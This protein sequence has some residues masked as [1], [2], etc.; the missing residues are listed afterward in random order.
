MLRCSDSSL[1]TGWTNDL[2]KRVEKHNSGLGAKYTRGKL[3]VKLVYYEKF[4]TKS[5]AM[6]REYS[7]K[8][9]SKSEK[10]DL[11]INKERNKKMDLIESFQVNHLKLKPGFYVSRKDNVRKEV[12]TTFDVRMIMPNEA[13][14]MGTDAVH[15]IE[16]LGATFLRNDSEVKEKI[17]YFGPMG[18]RT[19]FYLIMAGDLTANGIANKLKEM[20]EFI[21]DFNDDVPGANAKACGNYLDMNLKMAKYYSQ[22]YYDN[23]IQK[24]KKSQ[25][26][27][28]K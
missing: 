8:Q 10:E 25:I 9:F 15:A 18:C 22:I 12:I 27:Y 14:A 2:S 28:P 7:I 4:S 11:I 16:H 24:I 5:E 1:Y 21:I 19:G 23:V 13:P 26:R 20:F 3:P 17:I 6:S